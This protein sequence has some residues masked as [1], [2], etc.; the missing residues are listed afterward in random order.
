MLCKVANNKGQN[1]DKLLGGVLFVYRS[2]QEVGSSLLT[3]QGVVA[4]WE[5]QQDFL[6]SR[7]IPLKGYLPGEEE[8]VEPVLRIKQ[9]QVEGLEEH[10]GRSGER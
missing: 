5:G 8:V 9:A 7:M 4:R 10:G 6:L 3:Q 1:W 2:I